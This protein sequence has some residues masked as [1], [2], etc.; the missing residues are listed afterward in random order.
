MFP[1]ITLSLQTARTI[2]VIAHNFRDDGICQVVRYV[3]T[4][5]VLFQGT[6][7]TA[8]KAAING[9]PVDMQS[10]AFLSHSALTAQTNNVLEFWMD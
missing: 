6:S 7:D 9:V 5:L 10:N 4:G 2:T 8:S 1:Q 3:L